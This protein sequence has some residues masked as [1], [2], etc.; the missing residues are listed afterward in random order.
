M[1]AIVQAN[2][3]FDE[4][5]QIMVYQIAAASN[6]SLTEAAKKVQDYNGKVAQ[7]SAAPPAPSVMGAS[8]SIP[9]A[10]NV[11]PTKLNGRETRN[12]VA[13]ILNQAKAQNG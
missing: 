3:G 4:D 6:I 8:G 7:R 5:D 2:P 9:A 12:L 11:D 10:P 13:D 1:A